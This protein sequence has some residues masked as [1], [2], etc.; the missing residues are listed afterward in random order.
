MATIN[1]LAKQYANHL[2]LN[3]RNPTLIREVAATINGLIYTSSGKAIS[4][5]DKQ[6][7]L[8]AIQDELSHK[9]SHPDGGMISKAEDSREFINLIKILQSE[10]NKGK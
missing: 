10:I 2:K 6:K 4:D 3:R 9:R 1:E 8:C 5:E 7:I